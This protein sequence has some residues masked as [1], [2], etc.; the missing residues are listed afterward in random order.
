MPAIAE[1]SRAHWSANG[2]AVGVR[3]SVPVMPVMA[4]YGLAFGAVAA[5]KGLTVVEATVMSAL[6]YAGVSQFVALEIWTN[7]MTIGVIVTLIF[8]TAIINMRFI[9]MSAALRPWLGSLPSWQT[10]PALAL[11]TDPGWLLAMRYRSEG[12][13]NVG[14]LF[15]SGFVLWLIWIGSTTLGH[16]V[17]T[18]VSDPKRYGIDL[19]LP[20]FFVVMLVPLWRGTWRAIPWAVGGA[21][22]LLASYLM[23]GWWFIILGAIA[24]SITAGFLNER[25]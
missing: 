8:V 6:M 3:F 18:F 9:L 23:T 17:G 24:G 7:P 12:G 13:A 20:V 1:S 15:G 19:V 5:Q 14:A 25:E 11:L 4:I 21:T 10:Y 2:Y 16:Y 22:A